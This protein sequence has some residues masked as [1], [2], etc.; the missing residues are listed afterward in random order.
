[1]QIMLSTRSV[2]FYVNIT[3]AALNLLMF[4]HPRHKPKPAVVMDALRQPEYCLT[5]KLSS[6]CKT[7]QGLLID[8]AVNLSSSDLLKRLSNTSQTPS[9]EYSAG[10]SAQTAILDATA[11]D[12]IQ[13]YRQKHPG[14]LADRTS[15][16]GMRRDSYSTPQ[17]LQTMNLI[18]DTVKAGKPVTG[19][20]QLQ[21]RPITA[22]CGAKIGSNT[23]SAA[24]I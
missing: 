20:V 10:Q 2:L 15:F 1:M 7:E 4:Y 23:V 12:Q 14:K 8:I 17:Y 22:N 13:D 5:N 3:A 6:E 24:C 19:F 11:F 21:L 9:N 18:L 16:D